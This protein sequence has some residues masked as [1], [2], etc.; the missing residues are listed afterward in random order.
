M[1]RETMG[2]HATWDTFIEMFR[3]AEK[4]VLVHCASGGRVGAAYY[5]YLV[6]EEGM[7]RAAA[8]EKSG[9]TSDRLA[10]PVESYLDAK[11]E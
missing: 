3:N 2:T 7:S 8:R 9:L 6:A 10:A 5:A 1:T 4:P 11:G